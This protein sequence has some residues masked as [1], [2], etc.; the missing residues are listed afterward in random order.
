MQKERHRERR[1]CGLRP[2][3]GR[4]F[5]VSWKVIG[6]NMSTF[7]AA[8]FV[9]MAQKNACLICPRGTNKVF[10]IELKAVN[11]RLSL[12]MACF[13]FTSWFDVRNQREWQKWDAS[14]L[15]PFFSVESPL[16]CQAVCLPL[17][18]AQDYRKDLSKCETYDHLLGEGH[19][20]RRGCR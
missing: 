11:T 2:D 18:F 10:L 9:W 13:C 3:K 15:F 7:W 4:S 17:Q 1:L 14:L 19:T 6:L 16:V 20:I 12:L 5:T 8:A